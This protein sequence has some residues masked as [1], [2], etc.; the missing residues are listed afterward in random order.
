MTPQNPA[1]AQLVR[2]LFAQAAFVNDLGIQLTDVGPGW[3]TSELVVARRHW[4]QDDLIHAGV[5]ATMADHTA[6]AAAGSLIRAHEY[7][8]TVE[9]KINLLR[10]AQGERLTCRA[11]V[12]KPGRTITVAESEVF[13]HGQGDVKLVAKATVTLMTLSKTKDEG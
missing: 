3:C 7:V 13:V 10:A 6:G 12:L 2:Q 9:F 11:Q 8:L 1:Y 5:I 4:Q